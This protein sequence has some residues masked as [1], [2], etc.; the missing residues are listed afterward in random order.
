MR[1]RTKSRRYSP[2]A[3]QFRREHARHRDW[4]LAPRHGLKLWR[5][6]R[7]RAAAAAATAATAAAVTAAAAPAANAAT[8]ADAAATAVAD[9]QVTPSEPGEPT[10]PS[11]DTHQT[12]TE[13]AKPAARPATARPAAA[14]PAATRPAASRPAATRPA[15]SRPAGRPR[16]MRAASAGAKDAR[17]AGPQRPLPRPRRASPVDH[18]S[19]S[20]SRDVRE[21]TRWVACA[22]FRCPVHHSVGASLVPALA[23]RQ[24][25]FWGLGA[26]HFLRHV[27][28]RGIPGSGGGD[29]WL[30]R[31]GEVG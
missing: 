23:G 27:P 9:Q 3:E 15:T 17:A 4:G 30:D 21:S 24:R 28:W 10:A 7:E 22:P 6:P 26:G 25:H 31:G 12:E 19:R 14:R 16:L 1:D 11:A 2:E 18:V 20:R 5:L 29:C 8:S 13:T